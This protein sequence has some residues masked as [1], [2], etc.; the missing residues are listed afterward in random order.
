MFQTA[1]FLFAMA[2]MAAEPVVDWDKTNAETLRHFQSI[3]RINTS[4]PPGNETEV[5]NYL[6]GVFDRE[7]I[8][9]QVFAREPSRANLVARLKGNGRKKPLLILGHTDT[10]GSDGDNLTL[11][12]NRAR[13]IAG[14]LR[15]HGLGVSVLYTGA[16]ERLPR[17]RTPDNTDEPQNRRADYVLSAGPP[18]L[19]AGARWTPLGE[20][21]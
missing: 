10:V 8:G 11:S 2:A 14:Y 7:G 4:N 13:S 9:Y 1:F 19:P 20:T 6:K 15:E 17:V 12:Q 21:R 18:P 16:G 3:V 5:V